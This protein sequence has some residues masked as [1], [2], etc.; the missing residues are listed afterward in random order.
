MK[1]SLRLKPKGPDRT[2]QE[3]SLYRVLKFVLMRHKDTRDQLCTVFPTV[4]DHSAVYVELKNDQSREYDGAGFVDFSP[5]SA[6]PPKVTWGSDTMEA[7]LKRVKPADGQC[8]QCE[9]EIRDGIHEL[10]AMVK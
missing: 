7:W 4:F 8:D 6:Q 1:F 2:A 3:L 5:D 10:F 9:S